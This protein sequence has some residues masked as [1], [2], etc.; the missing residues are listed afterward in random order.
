MAEKY[1]SQINYDPESPASFGGVDSIYRAVKNEGKYEISRNKIRLWL[2]KQD[3]Y[4]LHKT[5]RYRFRRNRVIV[6]A[7]D[8]V[9]SYAACSRVRGFLP[10]N[11]LLTATTHSIPIVQ[12]ITA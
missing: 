6:G 5:V 7:I 10:N 11:R 9:V 12:P 3:T 4:T 8:D 1:L 2:Q